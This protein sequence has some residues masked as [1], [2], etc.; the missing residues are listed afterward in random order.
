MIFASGPTP[1]STT[2][3]PA[4]KYHFILTPSTIWAR[5]T[6]CEAQGY[7]SRKAPVVLASVM[8]LQSCY[9]QVG[10]GVQSPSTL[11]LIDKMTQEAFRI[12]VFQLF[13]SIITTN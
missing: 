4:V 10:R 8:G 1:E 7:S 6:M 11:S 2:G 12:I 5:S 13:H 9:G 3:I